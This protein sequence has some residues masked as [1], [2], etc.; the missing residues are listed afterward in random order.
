MPTAIPSATDGSLVAMVPA[1]ITKT[2]RST[3]GVGGL[4]QE[5]SCGQCR[6]QIL[7]A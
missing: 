6:G 1:A 5:Q 7:M 2:S 4:W 3:T